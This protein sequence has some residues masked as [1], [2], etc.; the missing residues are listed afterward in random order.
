MNKFTILLSILF[1]LA[2]CGNGNVESG[3]DTIASERIAVPEK[4]N[5]I[6]YLN[7]GKIFRD[8]NDTHLSAVEKIGIKP[9]ASREGIKNASRELKLIGGAMRFNEPY[10]VDRLVHSSPFLVP[11]AANLLHDIGAAFHDSLRN[12]HLPEYSIIVT[13]VLRTDADIKSLSKTN[14]NASKR[15]VHCYGTTFD[16][17]YTRFAKHDDEGRDARDV[18]LKAVLTEVLRD[19]RDQG[20]CY[21]KYEV[22]QACFHITTRK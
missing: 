11:E 5:K 21:V 13:S 8:D 7:A 9:L 19:L 2:S 12:K 6:L 18:D 4:P 10:V 14:V 22:K 16:I 17:T 20:R 1:L 15:S 3:G